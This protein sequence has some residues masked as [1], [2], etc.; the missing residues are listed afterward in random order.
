MSHTPGPWEARWP[1]FDALIL[2]AAERVI[3]SVSFNDHADTECEANAHLL[4][5]A[6]ELLD[7]LKN[8]I[9]LAEYAPDELGTAK[10]AAEAKNQIELARV[11][12]AKAEGRSA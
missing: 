6:P 8:L 5:A 12:I 10:E 4:A 1:K 7:A 3:A 9:P 11:A 2:D